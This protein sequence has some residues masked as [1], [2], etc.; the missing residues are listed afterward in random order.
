MHK[1]PN[2]V[3]SDDFSKEEI[4]QILFRVSLLV[5]DFQHDKDKYSD[6]SRQDMLNSIH[7]ENHAEKLCASLDKSNR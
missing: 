1:L 5:F 6:L 2:I 7:W 3:S 4:E